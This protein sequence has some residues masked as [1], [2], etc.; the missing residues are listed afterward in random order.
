[1]ANTPGT[2]KT[3]Q[4]GA[5]GGAGGHTGGTGGGTSFQ[6]GQRTENQGGG[7]G[8]TMSNVMEQARDVATGVVDRARD[9][10][11]GV[12]EKASEMASGVSDRVSGALSGATTAVGDTFASGKQY[13]EEE[14]FAG[15]GRDLT[16]LVRRNP[17]PSLLVGVAVGFLLARATSSDRS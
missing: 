12:A 1:M 6:G 5:T 2:S 3:G 11:S 4:G 9:M 13:F 16:N 14:G 10:A 15:V 8:G 7:S 17:I